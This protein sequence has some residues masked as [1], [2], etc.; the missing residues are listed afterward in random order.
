MLNIDKTDTEN[1]YEKR[2]LGVS[3][4]SIIFGISVAI[5]AYLIFLNVIWSFSAFSL[6][7]VAGIFWNFVD[8]G[9]N[10]IM[11]GFTFYVANGLWKLDKDSRKLAMALPWYLFILMIPKLAFIHRTGDFYTNLLGAFELTLLLWIPIYLYLR[12]ERIKSTFKF[13]LKT[14]RVGEI[15]KMNNG[16]LKVVKIEQPNKRIWFELDRNGNKID[17]VLSSGQAYSYIDFS[18]NID[19]ISDKYVTLKSESE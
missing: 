18:F 5:F 8:W 19:S 7:G 9:L 17:D 6:Y 16:Y 15:W 3:I 12:R 4:I 13:T 11:G 10:I 2:P 1:H 14:L